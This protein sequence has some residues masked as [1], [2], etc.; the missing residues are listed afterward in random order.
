MEDSVQVRP[1]RFSFV[2]GV[3]VSFLLLYSSVVPA[4]QVPV[5]NTEPTPAARVALSVVGYHVPSR[6]DR[7][8]EDAPSVSLDFIDSSHVLITFN[9]KKLFQRLPKCSPDHEDRLLHAA[10]LE[11]SSGRV[12]KE[13]DWYLHDR[14]RYLW[15]LGQGKFLLRR[16]NDLY[17]INSSLEEKLWMSS[18]KPLLWVAVTP[19]SRQVI[20]ETQRDLKT[21]SAAKTDTKAR[22]EPTYEARFLDLKTMEVRRTVPL[23]DVI[24]LNGASTGYVDL[25]HKGGIWLLRFGPAA[26]Q[27]ANIA[28]VKSKTVPD[29]VYSSNNAMLVGRCPTENCDYSVTAFS[30]A[31][32]RLWR[33]RWARDRFFPAVA[34][35]EDGGRFVIGTLRI[36]R[37]S[38]SPVNAPIQPDDDVDV[39]QPAASQRDVFEEEVQVL[40]TASGN[41]VLSVQVSPADAGGQNFSLSPDGKRVAVLQGDAIEVFDLPELSKIEQERFSKL[42]ADV[43]SAFTVASAADSALISGAVPD[44]SAVTNAASDNQAANNEGSA[45]AASPSSVPAAGNDTQPLPTI[46]VSAKAVVVDVVVTDGKGHPIRGLR[47]DEFRLAEDGKA[48]D[49][50]SFREYSDADPATEA[51]KVMPSSTPAKATKPSGNDFSNATRAPDRGTSTLILLDLLNTPPSDQEY[52]RTQLIKFLRAKP[53][54]TA[55]ALCTM[56]ATG[57]HLRLIQGFTPDETLLLAAAKGKKSPQRSAEWLAAESG[58]QGSVSAVG[59]LAKGGPTS[60]FQNLLG[61]LQGVQSEQQV[62]D[63]DSRVDTTLDALMLLGRYLSG[64]P[65]RKNVVWLSGSFPLTI[66][67]AASTLNPTL[68]NRNYSDRVRRVTNLFAEAMVS[69]YPVDIR[70]LI[71]GG[72]GADNAGGMGGPQVLSSG[73]FSASSVTAGTSQNLTQGTQGLA[74]EAAERDTLNEFAISTGGQAFFNGNGIGQAISTAV[75]QGSNYYTLSYSPANTK[76]DGKFR[77]IKVQLDAKSYALHYRQGYFADDSDPAKDQDMARRTRAVAMQ[78]GSPPARQILFSVRVVPIGG[79]KK[80]DRAKAGE[81]TPPP[82]KGVALPDTVEVQHYGIDYSVPGSELRFVPLANATYQNML[83]LMVTSFDS[84][85]K[86]LTGISNLGTSDLQTSAYKQMIAGEFRVHQEMDVPVAAAS[87]RIGIQ[88][89]MSS[90]LGTLDVALPVPRVPEVSPT[91]ALPEVEPD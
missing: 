9:P 69:V 39:Y 13:A 32:Q 43:P 89:Q 60:G 88:D 6:L 2:A 20:V 86:M 40:E 17:I 10:V 19:D 27:R 55:V 15:P 46:K 67:A 83:A 61:A 7:L 73:D 76:Y 1:G 70:G 34:R 38:A 79:K 58:T 54:K 35:N 26:G 48:Q 74:Q 22:P 14:R 21:V 42:Q 33:Q 64:V 85:G 75:E 49:V 37:A 11:V 3:A 31:G 4:Q 8:T 77:K 90:H 81:N 47:E 41:A 78:H 72:F 44:N 87:L 57:A 65:G 59:D 12:V 23:S 51:D 84:E 52:G 24:H 29:V 80:I 56:T 36:A 50:R 28:R 66:A 63:T 16:L 25:V 5:E 68:E 91:A 18:A 53:P 62:S 45:D 30:A 82:K 71:A